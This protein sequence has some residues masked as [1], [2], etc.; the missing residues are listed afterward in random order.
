MKQNTTRLY[1]CGQMSWD[2]PQLKF[3]SHFSFWDLETMS[4]AGRLYLLV[5]FAF[6]SL[7]LFFK[8][9]VNL[10]HCQTT[11]C[12]SNGMSSVLETSKDHFA[13][14]YW[15]FSFHS[16]TTYSIE[17]VKDHSLL[18]G[19]VFLCENCFL[20]F[21]SGLRSGR[22]TYNECHDILRVFFSFV[23]SS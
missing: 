3:C 7:D 13:K 5:S 19:S 21:W 14:S 9:T 23:N 2:H 22:E 11:C 18:H 12:L 8:G 17:T 16:M 4:F 6:F 15:S 20:V 10:L 1:L